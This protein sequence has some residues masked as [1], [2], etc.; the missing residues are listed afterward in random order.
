MVVFDDTEDN[1]LVQRIYSEAASAIV[2]PACFSK[3]L[4]DKQ[5]RFAGYF[6]LAYLHP[7]RFIPE[8]SIRNELG[9]EEADKLVLLRT[10]AWRALH[11][12]KH[13]GLGG[14]ELRQ[15]VAELS[16]L[17]RVFISAE[18]ELPS[19]L[20]SLRLNIAPERIHHVMAGAALVFSEGAT[21]AAEAAVLGVPTVHCS[22]LRPGY[23]Q[24][25]EKRHGLLRTYLH[26]DFRTA[27]AAGKE[28]L[29]E[30]ETQ[31]QVLLKRK[32][33][34]LKMSVDVVEFM[35]DIIDKHK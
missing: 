21:M 15:V 34:M 1:R 22:D 10:V 31:R 16:R 11:D 18:G 9:L 13:R 26:K 4:S 35:A 23:I 27:I 17:A 2:V 19:D 30:G 29:R 6:E 3:Q 14:E 25:L 20:E 12:L 32:E 5:S 8:T 33:S 24:D 28:F 7:N